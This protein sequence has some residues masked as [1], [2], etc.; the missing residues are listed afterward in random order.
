MQN[1]KHLV[2]L[3]IL[4]AFT[5][6]AIAC[7]QV[8]VASDFMAVNNWQ[9]AALAAPPGLMEQ[10]VK[11]NIKTE[12]LGDPGR[13][14]IMKIQ[15]PSQQKPL[16]L[17]DTHIIRDCSPKG[18]DPLQDPLCGSAGCAYFGY[19]HNGKTY[20][21]VFNKYLKSLLPPDVP[22][23]RVSKQLSSGLPCLAFAE[24]PNVIN[25][26][27]LQIRRFCYNGEKYE[28]MGG[29]KESLQV[30]SQS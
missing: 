1:L 4:L 21:Q 28:E 19:I 16:Y 12:W 22:F 26:D 14:S 29:F 2:S 11:E 15:E 27:F 6:L 10:V 25:A 23:L 9:P 8:A 30:V 18:C 24:L 5:Q 20:R 3:I 13:M 7:S 17:I